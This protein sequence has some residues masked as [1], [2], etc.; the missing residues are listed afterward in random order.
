[1]LT[2]IPKIYAI[3]DARISGLSHSEQIERLADGGARFVQLREKTAAGSE[4][5]DSARSA[6]ETAHRRGVKVIINDRVDIAIAV[7]ASGVHLGQ[8]DLPPVEARKLLGPDAVIGYS[9]HTVS[10]A[11]LAATFPVDY[12]AIGPIFPTTSKENPD[13]LVGISGLAEVRRAVPGAILVAIGGIT[14]EN[15]GQIYDAGAD[16]AAVISL[17]LF[18]TSE[19][20]S[21]FRSLATKYEI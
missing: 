9:T 20:S 6:V 13:H 5:Y 3:T 16:S 12:I 10:Q 7:K 11:L 19:I 4:F 1:M 15:I 8:N 14:E 21:R 2:T 17:F 18:R